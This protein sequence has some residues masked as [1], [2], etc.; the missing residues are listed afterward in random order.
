MLSKEAI[1]GLVA[2]DV[3]AQGRMLYNLGSVQQLNIDDENP[4]LTSLDAVV[5]DLNGRSCRVSAVVQEEQGEVTDH[6]CSCPAHT[7]D[8]FCPHAIATLLRFHHVRSVMERRSREPAERIHIDLQK[9]DPGNFRGTLMDGELAARDPYSSGSIFVT[10]E[11]TKPRTPGRVRPEHPTDPGMFRILMNTGKTRQRQFREKSLRGK[12]RLV[13]YL[14]LE[15]GTPCISLKVGVDTLYVVQNITEFCSLIEGGHSKRYGQ[16]LA[17]IH[18]LS[19][20]TPASQPLVRFLL[21]RFSER[22]LGNRLVS[23][24]YGGG[25]S[26][27]SM[28]LEGAALDTFMEIVGSEPVL[29]QPLHGEEFEPYRVEDKE[30]LCKLLIEGVSDGVYVRTLHYTTLYGAAYQY[31]FRSGTIYRIPIERIQPIRAFRDYMNDNT[32]GVFIAKTDLPLF[33]RDL[34]PLLRQHYRVEEENFEASEYLPEPVSFHLYL[35][36]ETPPLPEGQVERRGAVNNRGEIITCRLMAVYE[37]ETS[38]NVCE[39]GSGLTERR[40]I[41]EEA[42]ADAVL[43]EYL[44]Q[45]DARRGLYFELFTEDELY[46]FL[47][48]GL[49]DLSELGQIFISDT[50]RHM[51]VLPSPKL[52]LGVSLSGNLLELSVNSDDMDLAQIRELLSNYDRRKRYYRLKSGAFLK[53]D[54]EE[55]GNLVSMMDALAITASKWKDDAVVIPK[56]RAMYLDSV[57]ATGSFHE[58]TRDKQ[59]RSLIKNMSTT[60]E[61]EYEVPVSLKDTLRDYQKK[62]FRWLECLH[63]SGFGG[64]LADDMGLGKTLQVISFLLYEQENRREDAETPNLSIIVCPASLVYNWE[65]EIKRF[66]PSLHCETIVGSAETRQLMIREIAEN[67]KDFTILITSYDLLKRDIESYEDMEFFCQIVDEAQYIKN[68]STQA[69]QAVKAISAGTKFALTGTPVENRLSELW[70]IFDYLMPGFLYG[71]DRFR[72]NFE[73]PIVTQESEKALS[74]LHRM[75]AP[76]ILRRLKKD[77]LKDLPDKLEETVY[78]RMS[79]EQLSLYEAHALQLKM[80]LNKQTPEEFKENK[81]QVLAELTKLRQICCSPAL[82]YENAAKDSAKIDVCMELLTNALDSGHKVLVFSQ[83]TSMLDLLTEAA[84]AQ[85]FSYYLLVGE[86]PKEKR[87]QMV[88]DFQT[89]DVPIFFISL[90]AG[91]TGLN[92]TA[93]DIVIHVDPWWNVAVQNQATDRTHRIGQKH[94]VTVYQLIARDTVEEKIREMQKAKAKLADQILSGEALSLSSLSK[95]ELMELLVT[96]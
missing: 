92:L 55:M 25:R 45:K 51:Q 90:K 50:L 61:S 13:P 26:P 35:D 65:S 68:Q 39:R 16:K 47:T 5:M 41:E 59:F 48:E 71:Y 91:G 73:I 81:L 38:Y 96:S 9:T 93:A 78:A 17:F 27:K 64:I 82:V 67:T 95:E 42:E 24:Y 6:Y 77:V 34:L 54:E 21:A 46:T 2:A 28:S 52:Q 15:Y 62:G 3:W 79:G 19:A 43:S 60:A 58:F 57:Q 89:G 18:Q 87:Q 1:R 14:F 10:T 80:Q 84:R 74:L 11:N 7:A 32:T 36:V 72:Q 56:Y 37:D 49:D 29:Y 83:F 23:S 66:A 76:F 69:A 53:V 85:G 20:F 70:S 31:I 75:I 33:C 63:K 94:V 88:E 44:H 22:N 8:S 12:V 40:N 30:P 86:T 4:S